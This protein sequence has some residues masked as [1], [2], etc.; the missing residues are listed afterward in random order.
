MLGEHSSVFKCQPEF[1]I[2][3][4]RQAL[5]SLRLR[6]WVWRSKIQAQVLLSLQTAATFHCG[7]SHSVISAEIPLRRLWLMI[8]KHNWQNCGFPSKKPLKWQEHEQIE[9]PAEAAAVGREPLPGE[10]C[11][12]PGRGLGSVPGT[13]RGAEDLAGQSCK[14]QHTAAWDHWPWQ[15]DVAVPEGGVA[16]RNPTHRHPL[17]IS[18]DRNSTNSSSTHSIVFKQVW[19][20]FLLCFIPRVFISSVIFSIHSEPDS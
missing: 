4:A 5:F 7:S 1:A 16:L 2:L 9:A 19:T 10:M 3:T 14:H 8:Y 20:N 6:E 17:A 18:Q 11:L 12:V 13:W 15:W